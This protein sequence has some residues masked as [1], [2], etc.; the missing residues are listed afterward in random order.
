MRQVLLAVLGAMLLF[1]AVAAIMIQLM[2]EPLSDSD[3][4][5]IG[6]VSTLVALLVLFLLLV[7]TKMRSSDVFFKKRKKHK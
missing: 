4:L 2:P 7:S 5:V 3:Y 6:S 1:A